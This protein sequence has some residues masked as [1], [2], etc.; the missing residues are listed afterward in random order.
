MKRRI[1]TLTAAGLL[2]ASGISTYA[3]KSENEHQ[4]PASAEEIRPLNI[5]ASVPESTLKT[6]KSSLFTQILITQLDCPRKL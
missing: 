6:V 4:V 2:I 1:M 5:G 3:G